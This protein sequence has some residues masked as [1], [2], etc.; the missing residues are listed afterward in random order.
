MAF[1]ILQACLQSDRSHGALYHKAMALCGI[2]CFCC[3]AV[4]LY[5]FVIISVRSV[6]SVFKIV[7]VKVGVKVRMQRSEI[8][9]EKTTKLDLVRSN[10]ESLDHLFSRK[11]IPIRNFSVIYVII[12]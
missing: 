9:L 1:V 6:L 4:Y 2:H 5:V 10:L 8:I 7:K 3:G 11:C 12:Y